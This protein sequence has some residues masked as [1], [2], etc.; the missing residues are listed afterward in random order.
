MKKGSI[1]IGTLLFLS[2]TAHATVWYVHPDSVLNSIQAALDSCTENDTALV[3]PGIYYENLIWPNTQGINLVSEYGP[4]TTIIDGDNAGRVITIDTGV[5]STTIINGFTV[6]NG[7]DSFGGGIY[8]AGSPMIT[9]NTI[10]DNTAIGLTGGGGGIYYAWESSPTIKDNTITGN[11]GPMGGGIFCY[12]SSST[13]I[14][15]NITANTA[16]FGGGIYCW[17]DSSSIITGNTITDN[18]AYTEGGG[19]CCYT[20]SYSIIIGNI[21]TGN[22]AACGGGIDCH[23]SS[24]TIKDN[25]IT[26][27]TTD[28]G[29]GIS[30]WIE[31]YSI[32]IGNTIAVNTATDYG[33]GIYCWYESSPIIKSNTLSG[34][35]ATHGAGIYCSY[36]SSPTVDSCAI[37]GNNGDGVYCEAIIVNSPSYPVIHYCNIT[38]NTGYGVC[39]VDSTVIIDATYNWWGHPSGPGGLGPGT[40][41]EV[42]EWV[43]YVPWLTI[44][45]GIRENEYSQNTSTF[46]EISP[47]PFRDKTDIKYQIPETVDS[48]Q[49]AVG[50]IKI[51]DVDGRL[52]RQFDHKTIRLL[53]HI[54][55]NGT[56]DSN[57]KLPSGVYFLKFK[58]GDYKETRKLIL[59][60]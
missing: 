60:R 4:D 21:I 25:T 16:D 49:Y 17:D 41:D 52:V 28:I 53:N 35:T 38:E 51:Y 37:S 42:S 9:A 39:N 11:T 30:C 48:R 29:G 57:K 47:N 8:C 20:E 58:A 13:I 3:A 7:Y 45:V 31:S 12:G 6:R 23:R 18:T 15:N 40:G 5:D 55:W 34:N 14:D 56:D 27:N 33:G 22:T 2:T 43:D 54:T 59:L 44:L 46:L 50:S 36:F 32:I 24:P 19:I 1:L 26:G 10:T